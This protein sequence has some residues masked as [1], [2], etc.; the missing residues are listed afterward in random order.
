MIISTIRM[1]GRAGKR[2]EIQ[3]TINGILDQMKRDTGCLDASNYQD[4]NDEN[5]FYL[6][7][8]WRTKK[9]MDRYLHSNLFAVLLGIETILA[10]KPEIKILVES[11]SYDHG[12]KIDM[13]TKANEHYH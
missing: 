10:D 9:D 3:Q 6:V 13:Q 2:K 8:E 12:Q 7:E 11:S 5:I 1:K 4:V